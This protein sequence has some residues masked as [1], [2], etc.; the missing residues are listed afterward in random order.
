[1]K[2]CIRFILIT[3]IIFVMLSG[4]TEGNNGVKRMYTA[5]EIEQMISEEDMQCGN[6]AHGT[7]N[8]R[9]YVAPVWDSQIIYNETVLFIEEADGSVKPASLIYKIAK[10]LT[11]KK[12]NTLNADAYTEDEDYILTQDGKIALAEQSDIQAMPYG[13]YYPSTSD[14]FYKHADDSITGVVSNAAIIRQ[15]E[16]SITYIRVQEYDGIKPTSRHNDLTTLKQKI[17]GTLNLLFLGDSITEGNGPSNSSSP[18]I[19]P[20]CD[21]VSQTIA[22]IK[23]KDINKISQTL[24]IEDGKVNYFNAGVGGITAEQYKYMLDNNVDSMPY[25]GDYTKN[26]ARLVTPMMLSMLNEADVVFLAFGSNDGGGWNGGKGATPIV[27]KSNITILINKIKAIN[28]QASIVLV[29]SM[30]SNDRVYTNSL[31]TVPLLGSN[32]AEYESMLNEYVKEKQNIV[33]APVWSVLSALMHNGKPLN[34]FLADA[35]NHPN[36]FMTRIYAQTI[37]TT[38]LPEGA[39]RI[40]PEV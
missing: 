26:K 3:A 31:C 24:N 22:D 5:E 13:L 37:L 40:Y 27:F 9:K 6:Y 38:I 14:W 11:V 7:D 21:V 1:M 18:Y 19:P 33:I 2:N 23:Y 39:I 20:F 8:A 28:P 10:I 12:S 32:T 16:L 35:R 15:Y 25:A 30:K 36:D 29:S 34:N 4:C 17:N